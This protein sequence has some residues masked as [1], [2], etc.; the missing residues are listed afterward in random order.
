MS[1]RRRSG[2]HPAA[3]VRGNVA[4][5]APTLYELVAS[6][7]PATRRGVEQQPVTGHSFAFGPAGGGTPAANNPPVLR[8]DAAGA[9]V[10]CLDGQWWKAGPSA[11]GRR[12]LRH[13]TVELFLLD[14]D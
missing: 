6:L 13:R 4:D 3:P 7:P 5:I 12:R 10:A 1:L 14:D 9:R 11:R 8:D 2:G